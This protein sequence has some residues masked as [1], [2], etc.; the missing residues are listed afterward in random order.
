LNVA[1]SAIQKLGEKCA[2]TNFMSAW[3]TIAVREV[4]DRFHQ[5]FAMGLKAHPLL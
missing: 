4:G 1:E 2:K 5:N 3:S